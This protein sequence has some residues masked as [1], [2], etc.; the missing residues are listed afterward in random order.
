MKKIIIII[1]LLPIIVFSQWNQIG[2][3]ITAGSYFVSLNSSGDKLITGDDA[4]MPPCCGFR[5]Y[6]LI[7][8]VWS[9]TQV[10]TT[11]YTGSSASTNG[12]INGYGD[13]CI[14]SNDHVN[15]PV[16]GGLNFHV[17]AFWGFS[18]N[19][20]VS[21]LGTSIWGSNEND[22]Y[23]R[24]IG[25]NFDGDKIIASSQSQYLHNGY[26]DI[27]QWSGSSWNRMG[28]QL[29]GP[30]I[31]SK[32]GISIAID[33]SG[34]R[35]AIAS[36]DKVEIYDFTN[37]DWNIIGQINTNST[38]TPSSIAFN[39]LGDRIVIACSSI[40][41]N[42]T[43]KIFNISN[44][45]NISQL[46]NDITGPYPFGDVVD[47][48]SDGNFI[49][50]SNYLDDSIGTDFGMVQLYNYNNNNWNS[51]GPA[52]FG[53]SNSE[54]FGMSVSINDLGNRI[55][56][57]SDPYG[58]KKVRV[59]ENCSSTSLLNIST[60][61]DFT[62]NGT[63][64]SSTGQYQQIIQNSAGCDSTINLDLTIVGLNPDFS[65]NQQA[66][67]NPPFSVQFNN[68]TPNLAQ[69][70]YTWNFGD[71][72]NLQSQ[73]TIVTHNYQYNGLYDVTLYANDPSS[74][75]TDSLYQHE[76]IYC[77]GGT[78]N[79]N[80]I[81]KYHAGDV[82]IYPNPTNDFINL[83]INN[84]QGLIDIQ[85]LDIN[86]KLIKQSNERNID[87]KSLEEGVYFVEISYKNQKRILKIIKK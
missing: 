84:Y 68:N 17:G 40:S 3:D 26:V 38:G 13:K 79:P 29:V 81:S 55:G 30:S 49:I 33:S 11:T 9:A 23:G 57:C 39:S 66:F 50:T 27:Y 53:L 52:L 6:D 42:G 10:Q 72:N 77:T 48:N 83:E 69:Y 1:F 35:I 15:F 61:E 76:F 4:T 43:I 59:F 71:G 73:S 21:P 41:N 24:N 12:V 56:V 62:L 82:N 8:N 22:W 18:L 7:N 25:M 36:S 28:N 14:V 47:I 80:G 64:Y 78:N 60:C 86:C 16:N 5:V 2:N 87:L 65:S 58:E 37:N 74:G 70:N 67:L 85:I 45:H 20:T 54:K 34:N 46:G 63:T 44:T 75:C 32:F 51:Y 19:S 31:N